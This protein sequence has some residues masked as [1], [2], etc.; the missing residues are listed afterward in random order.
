MEKCLIRMQH[1]DKAVVLNNPLEV[2]VRLSSY[3][4]GKTYKK[5]HLTKCSIDVY[6]RAKMAIGDT[7]SWKT[8]YEKFVRE[9]KDTM[10]YIEIAGTVSVV[11][12]TI[13]QKEAGYAIMIINT[14]TPAV[15]KYVEAN[16]SFTIGD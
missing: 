5:E 8:K 3:F 16:R 9:N 14:D 15:C 7:P 4:R 12:V 2:P 11:G 10:I 6:N 1:A 13:N